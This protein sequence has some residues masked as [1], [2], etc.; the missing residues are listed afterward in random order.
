[1]LRTA[2]ACLLLGTSAALVAQAPQEPVR[3]DA[4][5]LSGLQARSIGP[6]VMSGRVAAMDGHMDQGRLTLYVGSASGGVWKSVNGGTTWKPVFDKHTMSIGAVAVDP[7]NPKT[8][9]VGT[10][11]AW[12]RNSV[13]VGDGVFKSTDGGETWTRMGLPGSERIAAIVV[14]PKDSNTVYVAAMGRLWSTGGERGLYKTTDGGKSWTR[15]LY[16]NED[17]GCASVSLDPK[18]PKVLFASLWKHRRKP[19]AFESG[20]EGSGLFR[21]TDGG[22][23]WTRLTG[24]AK[25]GLPAGEV[26]RIAVAVAPSDPKHVYAVVEAR[27]GA[28][29]HSQDGGETWER[30]NAGP[31]IVIRPFYFSLVVVDPRNPL[32]VYKPGLQLS[33]SEDGGRSFSTIAQAT[34]SDHHALFFH[35]EN[36]EVLYLGTDGGVFVS[37]DRGNKWRMIPNL[38]LGQFYHVSVDM[39]RPYH[40]YGGLQDNSSWK[41]YASVRLANKHWTNLYGGDGFWVFPDPTDERFVYAEAQGGEMGRVDTR[42]LTS[43]S[44]Q[45]QARAGEPKYRWS[46]NTPI[47]LSPTQPGTIYTGAQFLFRSKDKGATWERLGGDLTTNDPKKQNQEESGGLTVD[48]SAAETHCTVYTISESPRNGRVLWVGTDDGN[49]QVSR[50]GGKTWTNTSPKVP[51]VPAGTTVAWVEASPHAEGTAFAAFDGHAAGDMGTHVFRT[52]DFG[53]TWR[54]LATPDIKG[55]AHVVKQDPVNPRLLYVGTESGLFVS[56]DAGAGWAHFK[57]GDIPAVAVRD[58]AFHPREQD[59][60]LA[61][62]GRSLW[63]IDDLTPLRALTPDLLQKDVA[64]LPTRPN[65]KLD[66]GGDGWMEGDAVYEGQDAPGGAAI[67]YWQKK[68]HLVGE[69]KVEILDAKG[70]V[71]QT[72]AGN[73]RR[74]FNRIFW[75]RLTK[76]PRAATGANL[77]DGFVGAGPEVLEGT[78]TVRLTKNKD[79]LTAPLALEA[80]PQSPW[81]RKDREARFEAGM[82]LYRMVEDLAFRAQQV[83]DLKAA[84]ADRSA[85][86][87]DPALRSGLQDLAGRTEAMRGILVSTKEAGGAITGEERLRE[88]LAK[89]YNRVVNQPGPP[90]P[91]QLERTKALQDE[92]AAAYK[93]V[94]GLGGAL[95]ALNQGLAKAGL[96]PLV[97][98]DRAAWDARTRP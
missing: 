60:V 93:D 82:T 42:T 19:W 84:L 14:D 90:S 6:A 62:H 69:L 92:L 2:A 57:G 74:G 36:P 59:L 91:S 4:D 15:I 49:L 9:W 1:M 31:N 81:T 71:L 52:D 21:S 17:S 25:R 18:N 80:D 55:Y 76:G 29:F 46:W 44:V 58:L 43:R 5:A 38:P 39:A 24:D 83:L 66:M 20:G 85:Q 26:G 48:N 13:G 75:N 47:H 41:G 89:V 65:R 33:A 87:Q 73:K 72:L 50:D 96:A 88:K 53:Q 61:T 95:P 68:R 86:A 37:E 40:V 70:E 11:E 10:G 30:G 77:F 3:L 28:I 51:G 79:V 16:T 97:L 32:R 7:S 12:V 45:P 34:H 67:A 63:I 78:Y 64:L 56:V 22:A 98:L 54:S 35:P 8:V 94:D 27:D 23:T